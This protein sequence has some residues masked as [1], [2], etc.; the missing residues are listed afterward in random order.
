MGKCCLERSLHS[1]SNVTHGINAGKAPVK[2]NYL[3]SDPDATEWLSPFIYTLEEAGSTCLNEAAGEDV[4][5]KFLQ[6]AELL[7]KWMKHQGE[8]ESLLHIPMRRIILPIMVG[9]LKSFF[10]KP[11]VDTE[12]PGEE[13]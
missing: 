1:F 5:K 2:R 7:F 12:T 10:P 4:F 13:S 6:M 9:T 11:T 8:T 3:V